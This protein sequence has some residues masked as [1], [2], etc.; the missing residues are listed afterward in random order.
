MRLKGALNPPAPV[1]MAIRGFMTHDGNE[2]GA[3]NTLF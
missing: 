1:R 2:A 3:A